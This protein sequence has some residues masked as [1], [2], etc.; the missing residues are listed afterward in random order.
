MP[1]GQ[2][3]WSCR[4][5]AGNI[6]DDFLAYAG[7][8]ASGARGD[9]LPFRTRPVRGTSPAG[10]LDLIEDTDALFAVVIRVARTRGPCCCGPPGGPTSLGAT[11]S[12]AGAG[13]Q[14]P[15]TPERQRTSGGRT[16]SLRCARY[17]DLSRRDLSRRRAWA[18]TRTP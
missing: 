6:A 3:R 15:T 13:G 10:L 11:G 12:G 5:T 16:R 17:P 2:L 8:L 18:K 4:R 9:Y 14:P 1:A 7:Q